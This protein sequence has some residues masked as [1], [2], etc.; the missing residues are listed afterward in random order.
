MV[1]YSG[2]I[3]KESI[4]QLRAEVVKAEKEIVSCTI[5]NIELSIL[6]IWTVNRSSPMLPF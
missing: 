3:P 5:G 6:E 2:K 1:K 4:I